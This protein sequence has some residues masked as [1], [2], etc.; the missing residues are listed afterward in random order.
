MTYLLDTAVCI[1]FMRESAP[2]TVR[3][4]HG[5]TRSD[6]VLCSIVRFELLTGVEQCLRP[7][8]ERIKVHGFI[9]RFQSLPFDDE[10][11]AYSAVVR[12]ALEA[13]GK[14]IGPNDTLIAGIAL[15]HNLTLVTRNLREFQRVPNLRVEDWEA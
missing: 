6:I 1:G 10:C 14:P 13:R 12:V 8:A 2:K 3:R 11:A 9:S 4:V 15:R 7:A 5:T